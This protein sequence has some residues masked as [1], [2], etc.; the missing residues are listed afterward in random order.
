[1][2]S[3]S[4]DYKGIPL[5]GQAFHG[6]S[7]SS[8]LFSRGR[9]KSTNTF[10]DWSTI[11]ELKREKMRRRRK[12]G[13]RDCL[14]LIHRRKTVQ[15]RSPVG[16]IPASIVFPHFTPFP[17]HTCKVR[18]GYVW[19]LAEVVVVAVVVLL[20][21]GL[22]P[23]ITGG[24]VVFLLGGTAVLGALVSPTSCNDGSLY[25]ATVREG[26]KGREQEREVRR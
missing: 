23:F 8:F 9:G 3:H 11:D 20:L 21:T 17:A 26:E 1:M 22:P 15:V 6:Q 7:H 5:F 24:S 12:E 14:D 25:I 2:D 4:Y 13:K 10:P 18:C 16:R 19:G